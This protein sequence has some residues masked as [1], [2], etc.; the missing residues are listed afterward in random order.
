[1]ELNYKEIISFKRDIHIQKG[2][3]VS[4]DF[5]KEVVS[6]YNESDLNKVFEKWRSQLKEGK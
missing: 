1:M 6:V 3:Q 4:M 2:S 5:F